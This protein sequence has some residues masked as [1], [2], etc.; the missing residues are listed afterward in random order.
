MTNV[1]NPWYCYPKFIFGGYLEGWLYNYC[2][3]CNR[4]IWF[5]RWKDYKYISVPCKKYTMIIGKIEKKWLELIKYTYII[6]KTFFQGVY[7][8]DVATCPKCLNNNQLINGR[9][10]P[11]CP[12]SL[13]DQEKELKKLQEKAELNKEKK[14][15]KYMVRKK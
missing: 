13:F 7:Y 2:F 8:R 4:R 6:K 3:H 10:V 12:I 15:I 9:V 14:Q 1:L 11:N 5:F